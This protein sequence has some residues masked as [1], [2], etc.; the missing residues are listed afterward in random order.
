MDPDASNYDPDATIQAVGAS[1]CQYEGEIT[2][3]DTDPIRDKIPNKKPRPDKPASSDGISGRPERPITLGGDENLTGGPVQ[4]GI[5]ACNPNSY[6]FDCAG[7]C[8]G[9]AQ[10]NADGVNMYSEEC[11]CSGI[12]YPVEENIKNLV[13]E[14]QYFGDDTG[15]DG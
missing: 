10:A 9:I 11:G 14:A 2:E 13:E 6:F 4:Y 5:I 15:D 1:G 7:C 3:P 12:D 8:I